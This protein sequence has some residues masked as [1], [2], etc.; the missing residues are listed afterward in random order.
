MMVGAGATS[1]VSCGLCQAGT[2]WTGSGQGLQLDIGRWLRSPKLLS[3]LPLLP[4]L[5]FSVP[6]LFLLRLGRDLLASETLCVCVTWRA[7]ATASVN[8]SLC[9]EGTYGTG[10][11]QRFLIHG[12]D[13]HDVDNVSVLQFHL[14]SFSVICVCC[15]WMF[16]TEGKCF[17]SAETLLCEGRDPP[18]LLDWA[19][20]WASKSSI[21]LFGV[22]G[23]A[24]ASTS[25]SCML[26][27]AGTYAAGSGQDVWTKIR[28]RL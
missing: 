12:L 16:A 23:P 27:R 25:V 20:F 6:V 24:G 11:G 22:I 19:Y 17:R 18:D 7:G 1:V 28:R 10:S 4:T 13:L 9:Q 5:F 2:Y 15:G 3:S 26:C 8:C 14:R 21:K